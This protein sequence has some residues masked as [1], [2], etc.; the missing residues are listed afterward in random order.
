[1]KLIFEKSRTGRKNQLLPELDVPFSGIPSEFERKQAL[2]LP[3]IVQPDISRHYTELAKAT[4]G[5][6]DGF[7]PLGS[8]TMKYNPKINDE[9]ANLSGFSGIHPL[10]PEHTVQ[11][12][13]EVF[14]T[15]ENYLTEITGMDAMTFQPAAGAHGELTGLLMIKAYHESRGDFKRKKII[16]PDSAHGTNPASASMVGYTTINIP[17]DAS[18]CVDLDQLKA[19]VDEETAGLMLTNPNTV[20]IFE[21]QIIEITSII[22]KAGGL[23]YYDG[24]NLNAIMGIVK[25]GDMGFD[26]IHLNLHKTFSTP[27][28]GGGPGAGPIGCKALLAPFLPMYYPVQTNEGIHFDSPI[29]TIGSVKGFYGHFLIVLRALTYILTLGQEGIPAAAKNAVLNANYM[30]NQLSDLYDVSYQGI[31]MHEFVLTLARLKKETGITALDVSKA[32]LDHGMHPPTMYFPMTISEALMVE[33]TETESKETLDDAIAVYRQIYQEAYDHPQVLH[34]AP[35]HTQI[36]RLDEV[37]AARNPKLR[38]KFD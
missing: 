16:V 17:S 27:H 29:E 32:I 24:A 28:G 26:V 1:M 4:H 8:C 34:E 7:Y 18:G 37:G 25:P 11:G 21:Q 33:P 14:V 30:M 22:H 2:H 9:L 35:I 19:V 15:A 10:Q 5:V 6:N 13:L 38:F 23:N 20:G 36:R 3:E 31:C 12:C